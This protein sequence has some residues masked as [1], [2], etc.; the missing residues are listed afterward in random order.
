MAVVIHLLL[1]GVVFGLAG[2]L[3]DAISHADDERPDR[4]SRTQAPRPVPL[5]P[6]TAAPVRRIEQPTPE[7]WRTAEELW[8]TA[9]AEA[10]ADYAALM[11][12]IN[13]SMNVLHPKRD[14]S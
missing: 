3:V 14:A 10:Q 13:R 7:P 9:Q 2:L 5:P 8:E 1:C 11:A 4:T 6:R 12:E